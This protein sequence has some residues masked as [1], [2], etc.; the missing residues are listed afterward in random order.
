MRSPPTRNGPDAW[1]HPARAVAAGSRRGAT[2]ARSRVHQLRQHRT[3]VS[4]ELDRA[5]DLLRTVI[6]C[7]FK[8]EKAFMH[9]GLLPERFKPP[10]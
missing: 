8:P 5:S 7:L 6:P 3:W 2:A 9:E 1:F 4:Y 10:V